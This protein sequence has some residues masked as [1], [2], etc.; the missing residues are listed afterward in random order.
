MLRILPISRSVSIA[1]R[2]QRSNAVEEIN[3]DIK[4]LNGQPDEANKRLSKARELLLIGDI[5]AV[6][7]RQVS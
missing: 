1:V 5:D 7:Y 3:S 6:D 2:C 4:Q